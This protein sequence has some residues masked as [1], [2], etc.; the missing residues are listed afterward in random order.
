MKMLTVVAC[1]D[2]SKLGSGVATTY[3][4]VGPT[5]PPDCAMAAHC[6]AKRGH[7]RMC[8]KQSETREDPLRKA[9]GNTLLRHV[10]SGDWFKTGKDGR[11][12]VDRAL[13]AEAIELHIQAPWL[14]GWGYTHGADRIA[15]AGFGPETWPTNFRIL[16]S[17]Q[18][19]GDKERL[20]EDGWQT[21]RVIED[22]RDRMR[23]ELL[24]PVDAQKR[25]GTP[26]E[27]RTTCARCKACF[28]SG[29]NIAFLRF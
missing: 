29:Q 4:P 18:A 12:L 21:A 19:P 15:R 9:A 3:R 7:V 2:N 13:L 5:C 6:Y 10:V 23:G 17:C 25:A 26:K 27:N 8:A 11:K 14:T 1:G 20:N 22:Y 24:C 28:D 16:A